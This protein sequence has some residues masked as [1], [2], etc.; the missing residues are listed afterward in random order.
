MKLKQL[1]E[2]FDNVILTDSEILVI[3]FFIVLF[4]WAL[5]FFIPIKKK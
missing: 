1:V 4:I 3:I 5:D 2:E